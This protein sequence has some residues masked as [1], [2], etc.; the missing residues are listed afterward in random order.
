MAL[1]TEEQQRRRREQIEDSPYLLNK[2]TPEERSRAKAWKHTINYGSGKEAILT[3]INERNP[4]MSTD[5]KYTAYTAL[6]TIS[7]EEETNILVDAKTYLAKTVEELK[8]IMHIEHADVIKKF[9]A[10]NKD[11][12]IADVEVRA[13]TFFLY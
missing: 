8:Q 13:I 4:N 1:M 10:E 12:E 7:N 6:L 9:C 11:Y 2:I 5:T 3:S